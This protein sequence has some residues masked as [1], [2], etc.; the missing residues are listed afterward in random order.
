MCHVVA[1][2]LPVIASHFD[3]LGEIEWVGTAYILPMTALQLLFGKA[4][5]YDLF[6]Q[7]WFIDM[8]RFCQ[9]ADTF[10]RKLTLINAIII[11]LVGSKDDNI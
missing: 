10:G 8:G 5:L 7:S 11:F 6:Y 1:T 4:S 2:V 9:L 3:A